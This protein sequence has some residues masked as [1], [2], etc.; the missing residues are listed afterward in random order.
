MTKTI[1]HI[2]DEESIREILAELLTG[3]GYAVRSVA[4]TSEALAAAQEAAPDL[5]ISDLQLHEA[6]GLETIAALRE[7]RPGIPV[8]L[9]TGVLIDPRIADA[10]VGRLVSAY[11]QKTSSLAEI[12]EK[13]VKLIGPAT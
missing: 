4:T 8:I 1:L 6:D 10:T 11:I 12:V 9:L 2:D 5:I 13:V 3:L 7:V